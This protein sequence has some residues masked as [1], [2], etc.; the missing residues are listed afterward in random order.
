MSTPHS[1]RPAGRFETLE[2]RRLLSSS[3][4]LDPAFAD[5]GRLTFDAPFPFAAT[6]V[7]RVLVS[8]A[9][10]GPTYLLGRYGDRTYP[11]L[12]QIV[13]PGV[14]PIEAGPFQPAGEF[15]ARIGD[16]GQLLSVQDL[17]V[18]A[19]TFADHGDYQPAAGGGF[20][21]SRVELN[22]AGVEFF[23]V[24]KFGDDL[25]PDASFDPVRRTLTTAKGTVSGYDAD[26]F[27]GVVSTRY[28]FG[29]HY[30][31]RDYAPDGSLVSVLTPD[32]GGVDPFAD[33]P[34]DVTVGFGNAAQLLDGGFH[35]P[36]FIGGVDPGVAGIAP[37]LLRLGAGGEVVALTT[38]SA[39]DVD[40]GTQAA[41]FRFADDGRYFIRARQ[42]EGESDI[43][44][45]DGE[46]NTAFL[47]VA[48]SRPYAVFDSDNI[49]LAGVAFPEEG[50][51]TFA[52]GFDRNPAPYLT[53]GLRDAYEVVHFPL[54]GSGNGGRLELPAPGTDTFGAVFDLAA[55]R[56]GGLIAGGFVQEVT[57]G[58]PPP[59]GLF[60][61]EGIDPSAAAWKLDLAAVPGGEVIDF[62]DAG[63]P[64]YG[65]YA[66]DGFALRNAS[67]GKSLLTYGPA[68]G[69]ASTVFQ[70]E[71]WGEAVI[72]ERADGGS[73]DLASFAY[74]AGRW[75]EAGDLTVVGRFAGGGT[76]AAEVG[77]AL[78]N[79]ATLDLD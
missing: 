52:Y 41:E 26:P 4:G 76:D 10:G 19:G 54:E 64:A 22:A 40:G 71:N 69:Y 74:A 62:E 58:T 6:Q 63:Q 38:T 77:F 42:D 47:A 37:G 59:P 73:F 17:D 36:L 8:D 2:S 16:G 67:V 35:V 55:A 20:F 25:Q 29:S 14:A 9:P 23:V 15:V 60:R 72:L 33:A 44:V 48:G 5:A 45:G 61:V 21:G 28:K 7:E 79:L 51:V 78:K 11:S 68:Q 30:S 56:G 43:Y 53:G 12:P 65:T 39:P 24:R 70:P 1:V 13:N 34:G 27:G 46:G 3:L 31:V 49:T 18:A 32:L 75:G 57:L 50:G 66:E